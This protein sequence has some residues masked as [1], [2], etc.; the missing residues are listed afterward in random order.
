MKSINQNKH[1]NFNRK[2]TSWHD[3]PWADWYGD[4]A[5]MQNDIV[6][7][8]KLNDLGLVKQLQNNLVCSMAARG[9][10]VRN[11][12]TNKGKDTSG[13]DGVKTLTPAGKFELIWKLKSINKTS[14][15]AKPVRRVW[16]SKDGKPVN[17]DRSNARPLGIPTIFDRA[18]Q[19]LWT[20][21]LTPIAECTA[22]RHSYGYR[23]Y[24][25]PQ[26]A[27]LV[28]Y[29]KFA[30]RFRPDWVLEADIKGF[31]NNIAHEWMLKNIP[32]D[33][34]VLKQWLNA[35]YVEFGVPS[36]TSAGVPQGGPISPVIS[37]MVLDG[38][39]DFVLSKVKPFDKKG[40]GVKVMLVRFAD[41]FVVTCR[42]E[43]LINNVI[44]PAID[45]FLKERGLQLNPAKTKITNI[46][47]G[48]DFVG[49]NFRAYES[50]ISNGGLKLL[51]KPSKSKILGLKSK[52]KGLIRSSK[53]WTMGNLILL[54]NPI[55]RGWSNYYKTVVSKRIFTHIGWF[56]WHRLLAWA[57]K[58]H[59]SRNKAEV[60][61]KY[62]RRI[63]DRNKVVCGLTKNQELVTLY[64]IANV[65][66]SRHSLVRDLNSYIIENAEYFYNLR[67]R[68]N[69]SQWDKRR[70][71]LLRRVS[72]ICKVCAQPIVD[73]Q[74]VDIH[75]VLPVKAGGSSDV[76]N[77]LI[78]HR[79]CHIQIT[80]T[81]NQQLK[82][83]FTAEGI[84]Q[85]E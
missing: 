2:I 71:L 53:N 5:K 20:M 38:L 26:D 12:T 79:E 19:S 84:L 72:S 22:D 45:E 29:L 3:I 37:N 43:H 56:M 54:L 85:Q 66:I 81:K 83:R 31:F 40:K 63:G 52:L 23:P 62:Y 18:A 1:L 24:R 76:K 36:E 7:A 16:L 33:K 50:K 14:Y 78:V 11:V 9:I 27:M 17:K 28:L 49:F 65:K 51:I 48:F 80:Q 82:A 41:D 6:V 35:G 74:D 4:V 55:I 34:R 44:R 61:S 30:T 32:M 68:T 59:R 69:R 47:D 39:T 15:A 57:A 8:W 10:A 75:H 70:W 73:G 77:L 42:D 25:S 58:R 60:I 21:A 67:H 46:R 13:V 64:D